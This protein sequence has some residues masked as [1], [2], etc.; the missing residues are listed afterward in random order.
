MHYA[1]MKGRKM[2]V[3]IMYLS[4]SPVIRFSQ[5][6]DASLLPKNAIRLISTIRQFIFIFSLKRIAYVSISQQ[7]T[8]TYIKGQVTCNH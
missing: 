8:H 3:S 4:M 1:T 7:Y 5:K 2:L 6:T